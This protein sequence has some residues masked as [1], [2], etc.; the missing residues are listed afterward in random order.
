M[1]SSR[2]NRKPLIILIIVTVIVAALCAG[3]FLAGNAISAFRNNELR[4]KQQEVESRNLQKDQ[5]YAA[6]LAS[7]QNKTATTSTMMWPAHNPEGWDIV[8][9]TGYPLENSTVVSVSRSEIMN[10]GMLLVNQWHSRPE[11][12]S[13]NDLVSIGN[14]F[15]WKVQ[16]PDARVSLFT[17][18]ADALKRAIDAAA[19]EDMGHY[20]VS[21][22]YRSW[23]TQNTYFQNRVD[24]LSSKYE[25]DELIEQAKKSV[26][27]PGTSEFNTGLSWTMRLYDKNDKDVGTP[28]YSTTEEGKWM[29]ENCWKYGIVFRFP[30]AGWPLETSQDKSFKTG[31]STELNLYRYVGEGNAAVMH[32]NNFC[33]EEY[34][35]YLQEH[36]HIAVFEDGI[37]KYEIVRQYVGDSETVSIEITN[38]AGN[39]TPSLDNMGYAVTVFEY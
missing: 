2:N 28:K 12:F 4:K 6:R 16:V 29:N 7:F 5:E 15:D 22:G 35:E 9:L 11:D 26:N 27:Y 13:E 25:G 32:L 17:N 30:L 37:L 31:I 21:E 3:C 36:P 34:I 33:L 18:A 14:Y 24:K 8:D 38:N 19:E 10:N 23:D 20:M 1:G 39:Y